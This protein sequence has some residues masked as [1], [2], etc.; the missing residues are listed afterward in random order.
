MKKVLLVLEELESRQAP[1]VYY[2]SPGGNDT[3]TG[4]L[5][6][7]WKTINRV[8]QVNFQAGDQILFKGGSTFAG[9]VEFDKRDEGTPAAPIIVSSY[10]TGLATLSA[11]AGT[12]ISVSNTQGFTIRNLVITGAGYAS[13]SGDGIDF[14]YTRGWETVAGITVNNV[15]VSGFGGVG[16]HV[17]ATNG[18]YKGITITNSQTHDNG[19]GGLGVH[20]QGGHAA[21]IYVGR[22]RAYHNA[23]ADRT[24]SGYGIYIIGARNV[25]VERSVT[26]DNGW[27]PGNSGLTGGI[28]AIHCDRVLL[29]YN[30]S[31]GNKSA[32]FDGDGIILDITTNSVMQYN[33]TH[34]NYG[35][36]LFIGA[37][38][39][40]SSN[41]NIVRYNIS[42]NDARRKNYGGI[43]VWQN[44]S[45]TRI[46]NNTIF[47]SPSTTGT[48]AAIRFSGFSGTSAHVRNNIFVTTGGVPLVVYNG[49]GSGVLFQGNDYWSSGS[50]FKIQ[51]VGSTYS[52]LTAWRTATGAEKLN[53]V[54]TGFQVNPQLKNP[55]GGGT[56][57]DADQL[58]TLLAY[59]L[60]S[61]SPLR[62]AGLDIFQLGPAWDPYG[63]ANDPFFSQRFSPT[64]KDYYGTPLPAKGSK[65]FSIG[66]DQLT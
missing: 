25:V 27:L 63:F 65:L 62:N 57:N 40:F 7:P 24:D 45:N 61:T 18:V 9:N 46:Y 14:T 56:L 21:N 22:V 41:N 23:G 26:Y 20:A 30:E 5:S 38:P 3:N 37:E 1:A 16:I 6:A 19:E 58:H 52:S 53:G 44:V 29:Q 50:A 34:D 47:V 36:G 4:S 2:V 54:S 59:Q 39:G 51:W 32:T 33:Y 31:Y 60:L 10:G 48:P 55:G 8:N 43:F 28:E 17:E 49:G 42:Q 12:G 35:A 64:P 11:G 13:N 15:N 66:A